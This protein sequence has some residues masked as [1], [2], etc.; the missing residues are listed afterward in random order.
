MKSNMTKTKKTNIHLPLVVTGYVMFSLLVIG[1]LISTTIPFGIILFHPKVLHYNVAV[2]LIAFT[3]GA[4]LPVLLGY[5][6]GGHSVKTKSKLNH[7]FT[8]MLFGLLSYWI[9][10]LL[11]VFITLPAEFSQD[12]RNAS[13]VI[14]NLLPSVGVA[15]IA[16]ILAVGH[17]RSRH[18]KKDII[19]YRPFSALLMASIVGL[20]L[21]S[22]IQNVMTNSVSVYSFVPLVIV[23]VI[24]LVTYATLRKVELNK[25]DK[26]AWVAVSISVLFVAMF[27]SP[28]FVFAISNYLLPRSTMETQILESVAAYGFALAGWIVYWS[29]QVKALR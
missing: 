20:S 8:G 29:K 27:V 23:A 12:N 16:S 25:Y 11:S 14:M 7:H 9:M 15:V 5:V 13:L 2:M 4:L 26:V 19:G 28:Q 10:I 22:L 18:A 24:G 3:V 17:V 21:W 6:I 1:T